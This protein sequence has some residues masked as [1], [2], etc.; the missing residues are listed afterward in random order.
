MLQFKTPSKAEAWQIFFSQSHNT[1]SVWFLFESL[2]QKDPGQ[3]GERSDPQLAHPS[4][5]RLMWREEARD[6][7]E[8]EGYWRVGECCCTCGLIGRGEEKLKLEDK[9]T[10]QEQR[11]GQELKCLIGKRE[12]EGT[13]VTTTRCNLTLLP[14]TGMTNQMSSWRHGLNPKITIKPMQNHLMGCS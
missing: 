5:T 1:V 13:T 2:M 14:V 9:Q 6:T 11:E 12:T 8:G 7:G 10:V 3:A 4:R